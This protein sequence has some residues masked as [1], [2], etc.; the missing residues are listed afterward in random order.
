ME[1]RF[2]GRRLQGRKV[3]LPEATTALIISRCEGGAGAGNGIMDSPVGMDIASG[4]EWKI[5]G[6]A[7]ELHYWEHDEDPGSQNALIDNLEWLDLAHEV[8]GPGVA[9]VVVFAG[10]S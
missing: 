1:A 4:N 8:R 2:R 7:T 9:L 10:G 6:F 5:E 3:V